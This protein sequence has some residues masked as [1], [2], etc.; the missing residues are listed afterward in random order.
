MVRDDVAEVVRMLCNRHEFLVALRTAPRE[1]RTLVETLGV[2]RSTV[3]RGTRELW[4]AGLVEETDRGYRLTAVGR[5]AASLADAVVAVAGDLR[6][7][8]DVLSPLP[9]DAP[10]DL[11]L[12]RNARVEDP[13]TDTRSELLA[14]VR[15]TLREAD[16]A[17]ALAQF[18]SRSRSLDLL[19]E[20]VVERD[21]PTEVVFS[22]SLAEKLLPTIGGRIAAMVDR[23]FRP[24]SVGEVP[25][26]LL[27]GETAEGWRTH[28]VTYGEDG[29]LRGVVSNDGLAAAA[30]GW[31]VYRCYRSRAVDLSPAFS[32]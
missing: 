18:V 6:A 22:A 29:D 8:A 1:K 20:R 7:T 11:R 13:N 9:A 19:Y 21:A 27:L 31:D 28:L 3:D 15:S 25:F 14:P 17:Y 26:G 30:W 4:A 10:L 23:G 2:S 32:G 12:L 24:L 5:L 16:R